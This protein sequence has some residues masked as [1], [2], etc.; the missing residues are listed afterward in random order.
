MVGGFLFYRG[1]VL[2]GINV[3]GGRFY[4]LDLFSL[5]MFLVFVFVFYRTFGRIRRRVGRLV[6]FF[7]FRFI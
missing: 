4:F 6:N 1:L 3:W 7:G 2:W 5:T